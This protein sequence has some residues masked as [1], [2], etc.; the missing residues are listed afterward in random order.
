MWLKC[1]G[2]NEIIIIIY[3]SVLYDIL[4]SLHRQFGEWIEKSIK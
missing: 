4:V 3:K 2:R 1:D